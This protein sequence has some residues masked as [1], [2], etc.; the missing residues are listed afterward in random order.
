MT[1]SDKTAQS[2]NQAR[3]LKLAKIYASI[4]D[5]K[6]TGCADCCSESVNVSFLEF[7][8]IVENS[9]PSLSEPQF[10]ALVKRVLSYYLLEWVKPQK[11]PF[12]DAGK[13][14]II[15]DTRPLPCRL[16]G[17]PTRE[18]YE[19]NYERI[20]RQNIS[21]AKQIQDETGNKLPKN[22][23]H[24]KIDFCEGFEPVKWL[25]QHEIES[26][27]SK[28]VNLD[29]SLYFAGLIDDSAMNGDLV[30]FMIDWLIETQNKSLV[31]RDLLFELKKDCLKSIQK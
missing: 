24:R 13:K 16:F 25:G 6:C 3:L 15:Y 9:L 12:L 31:T 26:L 7:S 5:G 29:G 2:A 17:T 4:P 20:K 1:I 28:L 22:I 27:Y 30:S 23:V 10:D 21:I 8:N 11:C 18:A 14:C 19:A